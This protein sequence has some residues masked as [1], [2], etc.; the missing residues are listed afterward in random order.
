LGDYVAQQYQSQ[1]RLIPTPRYDGTHRDAPVFGTDARAPLRQW[2]IIR[3]GRDIA[4]EAGLLNQLTPGS[5]LMVLP[6]PLSNVR[7]ALGYVSVEAAAALT[8]TLVPVAAHG[9][10]APDIARLQGGA[11]ARMIEPGLDFTLRI[12][13]PDASG[14]VGARRVLQALDEIDSKGA[15]SAT[16]Q[17]VQRDDPYDVRL[18]VFEDKVWFVRSA[19]QLRTR[20]INQTP[21]LDLRRPD[22]ATLLADDLR[23]IRKTVNLLRI[24]TALQSTLAPHGLAVTMDIT[25]D[26]KQIAAQQ[27]GTTTLHTG[28]DVAFHLDN[29]NQQIAIDATALYVDANY[30][31]T[32]L[33]LSGPIHADAIPRLR[34]KADNDGKTV[35][36]IEVCIN[37][38]PA[39]SSDRHH[40]APRIGRF[41]KPD[42][43]HSTY[44]LERLIII[45]VE[46]RAGDVEN[47]TFN[48]LAQER[49]ERTRGSSNDVTGL[50]DAAGFGTAFRGERPHAPERTQL[51]VVPFNVVP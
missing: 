35:P 36:T 25:R 32:A 5:E 34:G 50:F 4:V 15:A 51:I 45:A 12:L 42:P 49:L 8:A 16:L 38:A 44:G 47:R 31:I 13:A 20:G 40:P 9:L 41:C 22:L 18:Q 10:P 26:R 46:A 29:T 14:G 37:A 11:Y 43:A 28:D 21:S 39:M 6:S 24:A 2:P 23:R 19:G 1:D 3:T 17:R 27:D 7:E 48:A 33:T 30:G